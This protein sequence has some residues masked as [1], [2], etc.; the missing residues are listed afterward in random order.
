MTLPEP[1]RTLWRKHQGAIKKLAENDEG[2]PR[3]MLGG[4]T[5]LA[6]RWKHRVST[7]INVLLPEHQNVVEGHTGG[8]ADLAAATG[9]RASAEWEDRIKVTLREGALDI[10]AAAPLMPGLERPEA[11]ENGHETV[12]ASAQILRGKLERHNEGLPRDAFDLISAN[13][14]EPRALQLAANG[15]SSINARLMVANLKARNDDMAKQAPIVLHGIAPGFSTDLNRLG[16][17]AARA[18]EDNRYRHVRITLEPEAIV[19][20]RQTRYGEQ[21]PERYDPRAVETALSESGM[22]AYLTSNHGVTERTAARGIE[23]LFREGK[24]GVVFD[25]S[26]DRPGQE[27]RKAAGRATKSSRGQRGDKSRAGRKGRI[28]DFPVTRSHPPAS[29]P[30][31]A[32]SSICRTYRKTAGEES[33]RRSPVANRWMRP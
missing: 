30:S 27:L 28:P 14:A 25:S 19:I 29:W 12:L 31:A 32:N 11:I 4:G 21:K 22:G 33:R 6:A 8:N 7:D 20:E 23:T 5:M 2:V 1:A 16:H 10:C 3:L 17:D 18:V 13:K 9:G 26:H 24:H 15:V